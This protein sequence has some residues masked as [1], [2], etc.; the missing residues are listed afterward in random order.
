VPFFVLGG[1]Y[2]VSGAQQVEVFRDALERAW[3]D[4]A[5]LTA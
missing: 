3:A 4:P 2:S 5:A 1:R